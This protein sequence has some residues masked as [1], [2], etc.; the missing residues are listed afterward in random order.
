MRSQSTPHTLTACPSSRL[1][2]G[3]CFQ[4]L[5]FFQQYGGPISSLNEFYCVPCR[6]TFITT[7]HPHR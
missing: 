5:I 6:L 3:V 7:V 4:P 1:G 2:G